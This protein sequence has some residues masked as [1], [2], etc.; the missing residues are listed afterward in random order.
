MC[1]LAELAIDFNSTFS[2]KDSTK[3]ENHMWHDEYPLHPSERRTRSVSTFEKG[4]PFPPLAQLISVLPPQSKQLLPK[5]YRDLLSSFEID[6][7]SNELAQYFPS[8]FLIDMNG[9]KNSWEWV[10][11]LPFLPQHLLLETLSNL[12]HHE[13]LTEE[14]KIRNLSGEDIIYNTSTSN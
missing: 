4:K 9:K 14:E 6:S 3:K 1:N 8:D 11:S 10:V 12:S 2:Y 7:V 13:H 5:I